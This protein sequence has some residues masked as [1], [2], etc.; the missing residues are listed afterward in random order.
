MDTFER[1]ESSGVP[2][3]VASALKT[4]AEAIFKES[5]SIT[6]GLLSDRSLLG[7]LLACHEVEGIFHDLIPQA[8]HVAG[9]KSGSRE[10]VHAILSGWSSDLTSRMTDHAV[11][12][13]SDLFEL[14]QLLALGMPQDLADLIAKVDAPKETSSGTEERKHEDGAAP[15]PAQPDHGNEGEAGPRG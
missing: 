13:H 15:V 2:K 6:A 10:R 12:L 5:K 8:L 9:I 1:M 11:Q 3:G 14:I 7:A 4:F